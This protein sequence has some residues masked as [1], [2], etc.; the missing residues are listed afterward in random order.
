MSGQMPEPHEGQETSEDD[1]GK[2]ASGGTL[3]LISAI[4]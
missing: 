3:R 4:K 1:A 2:R